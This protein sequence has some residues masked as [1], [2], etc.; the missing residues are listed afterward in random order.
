MSLCL[1]A[2]VWERLRL[3][4]SIPRPRCHRG[5]CH[6]AQQGPRRPRS[7]FRNGSPGAAL[8]PTAKQEVRGSEGD[9]AMAR[10]G[11]AHFI[12]QAGFGAVQT[13]QAS[14]RR[15]AILWGVCYHVN[16]T[17]VLPQPRGLRVARARWAGASLR[18]GQEELQGSGGVLCPLQQ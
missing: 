14:L 1:S 17:Q 5:T 7:P 11:M 4:L 8:A 15:K 12:T 18:Q 2:V 3:E 16:P 13:A 10:V 9:S 6:Y